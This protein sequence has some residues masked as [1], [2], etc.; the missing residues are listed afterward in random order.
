MDQ[1]KRRAFVGQVA[2]IA[3]MVGLGSAMALSPKTAAAAPVANT[4]LTIPFTQNGV[5]GTL[6]IT[7]FIVDGTQI[8]ATGLA[9]VTRVG[10]SNTVG[11]ANF[12]AP[13]T[14]TNSTCDIL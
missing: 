14:I 11:V 5:T 3:G 4:G 1:M 2:G 10:N 9:T 13:V 7:Q 6:S 8:L 12:T